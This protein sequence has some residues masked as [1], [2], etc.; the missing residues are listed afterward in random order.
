MPKRVDNPDLALGKTMKDIISDTSA[1]TT[2]QYAIL[3]AVTDVVIASMTDAS[4]ASGVMTG[5]T[6]KAG[7]RYYGE[8]SAITLTSGT[9]IAYFG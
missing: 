2:K 1:R 3:H 4:I 8:I 5:A 6:L 9:L 7:D